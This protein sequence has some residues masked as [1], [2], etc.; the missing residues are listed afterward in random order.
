MSFT[1]PDISSCTL[2][3]NFLRLFED[4]NGVLFFVKDLECRLVY[5]NL[6]LAEHLGFEATEDLIGLTDYDI[7]P[8]EQ[9]ERYREDDRDVITS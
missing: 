4:M 7:F 6:A 2:S 9:A 1:P 3:T 5:T 8:R